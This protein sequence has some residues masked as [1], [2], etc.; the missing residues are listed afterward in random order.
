MIDEERNQ[1]DRPFVV[2]LI[3][4]ARQESKRGRILRL[5][6]YF[7]NQDARLVEKVNQVRRYRNWVAH[8]RRTIRPAAVHPAEA[9]ERLKQFLDLFAQPIPEAG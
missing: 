9:H 3:D 4:E 1:Q 6:G 2:P 8:G 7:R 5:L